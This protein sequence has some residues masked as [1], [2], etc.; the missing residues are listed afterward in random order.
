LPSDFHP[1][2]WRLQLLGAGERTGEV[3][4]ALEDIGAALVAN[5]PAWGTPGSGTAPR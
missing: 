2:S 1:G 5:G 4:E 3:E